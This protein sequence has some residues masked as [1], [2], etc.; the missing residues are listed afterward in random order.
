MGVGVPVGGGVGLTGAGGGVVNTTLA[1]AW[2]SCCATAV[3]CA[4]TVTGA[5]TGGGGAV[6]AAV[7]PVE[8]V[9]VIWL[10]TGFTSTLVR[11][12]SLLSVTDTPAAGALTVPVARVTTTSP[13]RVV[14]LNVKVRPSPEGRYV[15]LNVVPRIPAAPTGVLTVNFDSTAPPRLSFFTLPMSSPWVSVIAVVDTLGSSV[16]LATA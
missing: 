12:I 5:S 15:T 16:S 7:C 4:T 8:V 14:R 3:T 11:T 13:C 9:A 10:V 1:T 2:T 6:T